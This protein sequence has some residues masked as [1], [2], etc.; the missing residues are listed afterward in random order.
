MLQTTYYEVANRLERIDFPSIWPGFSSGS[1][2]LYQEKLACLG[3]QLVPRPPEFRGN[4]AISW[5]GGP[6]AIWN[7]EQETDL[8]LLA[9]CLVHELFHAHQLASGETRFPQ[10][11]R[12]ALSPAPLPSLASRLQEGRLLAQAVS[13][14]PDAARAH[15]TDFCALRRQRQERPECL[16]ECLVETV[17]GTAEFVGLQALRTL[18]PEK[19][20]REL[21]RYRALLLHPGPLLTDPRRMAYYT[22]ALLLVSAQEAGLDLRHL[23][24]GQGLPLFAFL[25][26]LLPHT[27]PPP[28]SADTLDEAA[29]LQEA[30]DHAHRQAVNGFLAQN[31]PYQE[32]PFRICGYD[33]MNQFAVDG[34]LFCTHFLALQH[35]ATGSVHTLI[36]QSLLV[37]AP[38][39]WEEALGVY[40]KKS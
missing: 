9:S 6:L 4:T 2:A 18:S 12:L 3:G 10:D 21:D 15:L 29:P 31:P 23:L 38:G 13:A 17:E 24:P 27:S 22:G 11:I 28:L 40:H 1:F 30:Q 34:N 16:Q 14:G 5:Q 8:D 7:L 36:G 20:Q 37:L 35:L 32:G 19:Y 25:D 39:S 26:R 33:P